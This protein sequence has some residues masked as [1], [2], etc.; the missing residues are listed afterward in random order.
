VLH[1][2]GRSAEAVAKLKEAIRITP[3]YPHWYIA[4]LAAAYRES[5]A[6]GPSIA[7]ARH[8]VR[9]NPAD[10]DAH[11]ILCGDL[12]LAGQ[13]QQAGK[14]AQE[15]LAIDPRFSLARYAESQPYR[16]PATLER[17]IGNLRESGLPD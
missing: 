5:G 13:S 7:T 3:V 10:L 14:E 2:C 12:S 6:L 8:G 1:Y 15:I 9:L 16:N 17:L 4:L 11:L